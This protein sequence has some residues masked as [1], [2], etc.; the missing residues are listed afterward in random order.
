MNKKLLEKFKK[1]LLMEKQMVLN[2]LSELKDESEQNLEEGP[3]DSVDIASLE[4]SQ[5][6]IQKLG[7]RERKH[8]DK[9]ER[10]LKKFDTDEYGVC[11]E[12]GEEIAAA[13]LEARPIA[14]LCIDCK[15]LQEQKERQ[16][17]D[18]SDDDDDSGW[19]SGESVSIDSDD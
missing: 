3:G 7:T 6:A 4:I 9:V 18:E 10:A 12:C 19:G 16:Y 17:T 14:Q 2:H 11:E 13:R 5:A 8:L 15:R 1:Q